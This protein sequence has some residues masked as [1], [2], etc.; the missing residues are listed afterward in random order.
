MRRYRRISAGLGALVFTAAT[1]VIP[2]AATASTAAT[3]PKPSLRIEGPVLRV[4]GGAAL[5]VRVSVLCPK[6]LTLANISYNGDTTVTQKGGRTPAQTGH[7]PGGL[8]AGIRCDGKTRVQ[9][10]PV[11]PDLPTRNNASVAAWP[12]S[13]RPATASA[14][15]EYCRGATCATVSTKGAL[16]VRNATA[17]QS[18]GFLD[19][20]GAAARLS[21]TAAR[22]PDGSSVTLRTTYRCASQLQPPAANLWLFATLTQSFGKTPTRLNEGEVGAQG[23]SSPVSVTGNTCDGRTHPVT[24]SVNSRIMRNWQRGAAYASVYQAYCTPAFDKPCPVP[25]AWSPIKIK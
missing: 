20:P 8:T 24:F 7:A 6:G 23:G 3:P 16:G 5:L 2:V 25:A 12:W 15:F 14:S 19:L 10:I 21:S 17:S 9:T 13:L 18:A 1:T 11:A 22:S 4:Q